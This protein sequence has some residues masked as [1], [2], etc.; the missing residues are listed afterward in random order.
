MAIGSSLPWIRWNRE[1]ILS[2]APK[3]SGVYAIFN[4]Q[5]WNYFG[6]SE[7][8][9]GR[10]LQHLSGD[11]PYINRNVPTGFQFELVTGQAQRMARQNELIANPGSLCNQR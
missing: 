4:G 3:A 10:L 9:Q 11:I 5:H 7:D 1:S 6:E 2:E 8:I